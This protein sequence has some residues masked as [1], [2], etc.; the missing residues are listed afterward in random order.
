[1]AKFLHY[2][3]LLL[4]ILLIKAA[5]L[6]WLIQSGAIGLGPD[7]AQYWTWSQ[8]LSPGYYSKPPGIAWQI[9]LG[10]ALFGDT[11]LGV[12]FFSLVIGF[13]IPLVIYSMGKKGG[14]SERASFFS[15]IAFA[16][17]PMGFLSSLFAI[18]DGGSVLFFT[19]ALLTL[20]Q[21]IY[22][23]K[24]DYT[25]A[26]LFVFAGALFKWVTYYLWIFALPLYLLRR[27]KGERFFLGVAIS[28]LALI[29]SLIWNISHDF[30]TFLHVYYQAGSKGDIAPNKELISLKS[31]A[32]FM[33]A[34]AALVSPLLFVLLAISLV[35]LAAKSKSF[36]RAPA[37]LGIS[38]L[39]T[40]A[41]FGALSFFMK[42]QG[43]WCDFI[44]PAAFLFMGHVF[45]SARGRKY[46]VAGSALSVLLTGYVLSLPFQKDSPLALQ[47]RQNPL[48]HN[49]GWN[50]FE[51]ALKK[52]GY[53][54][55]AHFLF[56]PKYQTVSLLSF[57]GPGKK[58]A[59]FFN[60]FG[61]RLNQFSFWKGMK[62]E[63]KGQSGFFVIVENAPHIETE[64]QNI[65]AT[66]KSLEPYF[67]KVTFRG[68]YPLYTSRENPAKVAFVYFAEN[69][70]G[71]EPLPPKKY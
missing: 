52:A 56:A 50:S 44:Y 32:D 60:L 35:F 33:G 24:I 22:R 27:Q 2:P 39:A 43:N 53:D 55:K 71:E 51:E 40:L 58:R 46:L 48:K 19:M 45:D 13:A 6:V 18:T 34:E 36:E 65:A 37:F 31:F 30:V 41:V 49:L 4:S 8:S 28:L 68:E 10:T 17:S 3:S 16:L 9:F 63:R 21:G 5:A 66:V 70:N 7:E 67:Q 29:P 64:R 12:R 23:G 57:Y 25:R 61:A 11:E 62:E 26:G 15:A 38:T 20:Y 14:I 1:M 47:Y 42:I 54:E 69:F 59:Y